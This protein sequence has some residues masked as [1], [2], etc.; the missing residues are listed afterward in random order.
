MSRTKPTFKMS[1][2]FIY[3]ILVYLIQVKNKNDGGMTGQYIRFV[4]KI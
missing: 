2:Y 4:V 3:I 1:R